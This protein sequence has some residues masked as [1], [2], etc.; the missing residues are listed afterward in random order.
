MLERYRGRKRI[1]EQV[2]L[3]CQVFAVLGQ[4]PVQVRRTHHEDPFRLDASRAG[5]FRRA[6][7]AGIYSP[8]T[9]DPLGPI[10]ELIA[11]IHPRRACRGVAQASIEIARQNGAAAI[12]V[13]DKQW[14]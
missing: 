13:T 12:G 8:C 1:G 11:G 2:R 3:G 7:S 4:Q 14:A 6:V 5:D 10:V 9:E